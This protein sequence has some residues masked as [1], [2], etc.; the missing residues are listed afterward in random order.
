MG[1]TAFRAVRVYPVGMKLLVGMATGIGLLLVVPVTNAGM[2]PDPR[3]GDTV[4]GKSDGITYVSDPDFA[5]MAMSL[6][7]GAT[8]PDVPGK[9]R[10]TGGGFELSGG[11]DATQ[12]IA[13]SAPSDLLDLYGDDDLVRD[14]FWRIGAVVSVGTTL[15]TYVTCAKW[16]SIKQ[17]AVEVPDGSASERKHVAKCGRGQ[18]S[19][20]GGGI[21][22]SNSYVSSMFPKSLTKWSFRAFDGVGGPG[23]M[24]NYFVCVRNRDL[25][26]ESR[27]FTAPANASSDIIT[28]TCP[29]NRSAVGGGAKSGGDPGALSL[30]TSMPA[31]DGDADDIPQNGWAVRA[32][33]TTAQEQD[34]KAFAICS[35]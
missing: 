33:N 34:I 5:A 18:I 32:Y 20:G 9:W 25:T 8:C 3:P 26:R 4:L 17:K 31:D 16:D 13:S 14:D 11:A 24:N 22:S 30:R 29:A 27:A 10:V 1:R 2:A 23:G 35:R 6:E 21:G 19:G 15:T 28:A 12:R 7:G